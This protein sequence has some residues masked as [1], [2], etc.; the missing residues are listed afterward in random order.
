M[1]IF[2]FAL[3]IYFNSGDKPDNSSNIELNINN[4]KIGETTTD[5]IYNKSKDL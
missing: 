5:N 2:G 3:N 4:R 1:L